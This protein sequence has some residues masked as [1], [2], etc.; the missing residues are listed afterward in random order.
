VGHVLRLAEIIR[1][2]DGNHDKGADALAE[3]ILSH[4]GIADV[5]ALSEPVVG[6]AAPSDAEP[7]NAELIELRDCAYCPSSGERHDSETDSSW[8]YTSNY[9]NWLYENGSIEEQ[10]IYEAKGL[11]EVFNAGRRWGTTPTPKVRAP[12]YEDLYDLADVFNGDPVPAMRRALEL[13]GN[14]TTPTPIPVAERPW[15]RDGW[16]DADGRCWF[17]R[18]AEIPCRLANGTLFRWVLDTPD[19]DG[20]PIH[21]THSLPFHALPLPAAPG[22]GA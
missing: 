7:S 18:P 21:D 13:W 14:C 15:E 6:A 22:E 5:P 8:I 11:R 9:I 12:S 20:E 19:W 2:L 1:E 10:E 17:Y 16:C 4:P 3:A